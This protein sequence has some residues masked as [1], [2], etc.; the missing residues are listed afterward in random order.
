MTPVHGATVIR[1]KL[2]CSDHSNT[3]EK[4]NYA[5]RRK[6]AIVANCNNSEMIGRR[7][8]YD[9]EMS[10]GNSSTAKSHASSTKSF[11]ANF[12][13][14]W[15]E[16]DSI[17]DD[18]LSLSSLTSS[19]SHSRQ[20][21]NS[22]TKS[23][24]LMVRVESDNAIKLSLREIRPRRDGYFQQRGKHRQRTEYVANF[25]KRVLW[26]RVFVLIFCTGAFF[27]GFSVQRASMALR[28]LASS[29]DVIARV[30]N[31]R[32]LQTMM[33]RWKAPYKN[34]KWPVSVRDEED[35][36]ELIQH[37]AA[38]KVT[39]YVPKFY[40]TNFNGQMETFG[41]GKLLTRTVA[42]MVGTTTAR[43]LK[44]SKD[45]VSV[46]T[47]YIGIASYRDWHCR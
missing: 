3:I 39:L 16:I 4:V 29:R 38:D 25:L 22:H 13:I 15:D 9:E 44:A 47:I 40:L 43:G 41:D 35:N 36:F 18:S 27:S 19:S 10:I 7:S 37:P 45:I 20:R 28:E 2:G 31:D 8:I 23:R 12:S 26:V 17:A 6:I 14:D 5:L 42:D 33:Y 30:S 11:A 21:R 32:E 34:R 46:R 24:N 1:Y